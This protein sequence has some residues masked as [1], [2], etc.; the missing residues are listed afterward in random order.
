MQGAEDEENKISHLFQS[1]L[2][3]MKIGIAFDQILGHLLDEEFSDGETDYLVHEILMPEVV[4]LF[5][6]KYSELDEVYGYDSS[7]EDNLNSVFETFCKF[8]GLPGDLQNLLAATINNHAA[9]KDD[10]DDDDDNEAVF[11]PNDWDELSDDERQAKVKAF[12]KKIANAHLDARDQK[13][14]LKNLDIGDQ[15]NPWGN[16]GSRE[17]ENF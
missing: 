14:F 3:E 16:Q 9:A 15:E 1:Y 4:C 2:Q 13:P 7:S 11:K 5:A 6:E 10:E 8:E 12:L 17:G